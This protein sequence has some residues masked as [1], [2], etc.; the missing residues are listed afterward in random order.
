MKKWF[1]RVWI[2]IGVLLLLLVAAPWFVGSMLPREHV[3]TGEAVIAAPIADVW[4][5]VSAYEDMGSWAPDMGKVERIEDS[6]GRP[7]FREERA[8]G[9]LTFTFIEVEAPTRLVVEVADD[10]GYFGGTW[11]YE[12]SAADGGTR[13][14]IT[15]DGWAEPGYFRFMLRVFGTDSTIRNYLA[16]LE[17]KH[18]G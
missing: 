3:G 10:V 2:G 16:A 8:E 14:G 11:T 4:R 5:T 9:T 6:D 12:L 17:Q 18:A 15:E 7:R 13:V 1:V